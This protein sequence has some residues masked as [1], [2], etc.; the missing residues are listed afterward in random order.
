M[1]TLYEFK[2][3]SGIDELIEEL[4][5]NNVV[6]VVLYS[7]LESHAKKERKEL[8]DIMTSKGYTVKYT[9]DYQQIIISN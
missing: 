4:K 6:T 3:Y 7:W 1:K 5:T 2:T 8:K 9:K